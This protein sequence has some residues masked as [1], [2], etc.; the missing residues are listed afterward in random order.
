MHVFK[1]KTFTEAC[2]RYPVKTTSIMALYKVLEMSAATTPLELRQS[3]STLDKFTP[4]S[5]WWVVDI[6]GNELRLIA[7]IDFAKQ[8]VYVKHLF[9]HAEYD[10][11]NRWYR[12]PCNQ[13]VMP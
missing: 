9:N 12:T 8:R 5:G 2:L 13:G 11:A 4:R 6:G 3:L 7:A 10:K 1:K